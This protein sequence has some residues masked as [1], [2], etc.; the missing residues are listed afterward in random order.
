MIIKGFIDVSFVDWDG[1]I[2]SVIWTPGCNFR[3][4]FCFNKTLVLNPDSLPDVSEEYIL[5][6]LERNRSL[7]D[8]LCITGGEPTL[9]PDLNGFCL[10]I[11]RLG[12][13]VKLDSNGSNPEALEYLISSGLVDFIALDIKAPLNVESYRRAVGVQSEEY[14]GKIMESIRLLM[15]SNIDYEFRTTIVPNLHGEFE[16]EQICKTIKGA[17]KYVLQA[18][19]PRDPIDPAF[20]DVEPPSQSFMLQLA[21]IASKYVEKVSVRRLS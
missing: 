15:G 18:Y 17:K 10:K 2:V 4:P 11:K 1:H 9:Q 16:V 12:L 20:K 3:C 14:V 19:S 13:K 8:G 7:L 21:K 5:D 6:F